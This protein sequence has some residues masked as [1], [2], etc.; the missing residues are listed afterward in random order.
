M[1]NVRAEIYNLAANIQSGERPTFPQT[2]KFMGKVTVGLA[3]V[4]EVG[5]AAAGVE[6]GATLALPLCA[7]EVGAGMWFVGYAGSEES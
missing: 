2:L 7:A 4:A 6:S 5:L 3:A 1:P